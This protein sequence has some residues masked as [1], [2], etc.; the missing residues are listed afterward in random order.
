MTLLEAREAW[1]KAAKSEGG[2][3]P[4]CDRWGK[5]YQRGINATMAAGVVWLAR[6]TADDRP[7]KDWDWIDVPRKGPRWMIASNQFTIMR[8][9]GLVERNV[10]LPGEDKKFSGWW[11]ATE[12]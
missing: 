8:W 11:R 3:C 1:Y 7:Q 6:M 2:I 10:P 12:L 9:W 5:W 4:C